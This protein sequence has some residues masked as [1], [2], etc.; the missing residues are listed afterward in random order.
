LQRKNNKLKEFNSVR[1][2]F[3]EGNTM[4]IYDDADFHEKGHIKSVSEALIYK[5]VFISDAKYPM[6]LIRDMFIKL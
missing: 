4:T 1:G 6:P 3:L 2:V 5:R